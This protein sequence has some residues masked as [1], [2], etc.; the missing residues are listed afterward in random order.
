MTEWI[1]VI[2]Q[3]VLVGADR[4]MLGSDYPVGEPAPIAFVRSCSLSAAE[5]ENIIGADAARLFGP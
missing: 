3:G 5:Q 2:V 1:N 4:V